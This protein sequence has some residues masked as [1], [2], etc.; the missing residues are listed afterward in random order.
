MAK[1]I[2]WLVPASLLGMLL[3]LSS[4]EQALA[5]ITSNVLLRVRMIQAGKAQGT[6]CYRLCELV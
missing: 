3:L 4:M 1:C 2:S 6:S 5:Q